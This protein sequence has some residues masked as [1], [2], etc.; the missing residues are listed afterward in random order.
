MKRLST[1][2]LVLLV[3][4]V[5]FSAPRTAISKDNTALKARLQYLYSIPEIK[6]VA[7]DNNTVYVYFNPLPDDWCL[8]IKMAAVWGNRA[9]G[10]GVHVWAMKDKSSFYGEITARHGRIERGDNC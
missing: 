9:H 1:V 7:F 8:I 2:L 5:L 10:F 6:D 3:I 4:Q